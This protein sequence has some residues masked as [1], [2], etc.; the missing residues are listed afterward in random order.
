MFRTSNCSSSGGGL[1]RQLVRSLDR[2]HRFAQDQSEKV[3]NKA[4]HFTSPSS[5]LI[6]PL[7]SLFSFPIFYLLSYF[8]NYLPSLWFTF[9]Y[10]S[11]L[12]SLFP[13]FIH[14]NSYCIS[15]DTSITNFCINSSRNS[16]P[17]FSVCIIQMHYKNYCRKNVLF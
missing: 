4:I 2:K 3:N 13:F 8:F 16:R 1:Y 12:P 5:S 14:C 15:T 7:F 10:S 6:P 9:V 11:L 17:M